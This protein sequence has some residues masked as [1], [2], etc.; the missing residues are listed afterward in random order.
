[1]RFLILFSFVLF[2]CVSCSKFAKVQK[3]SDYNLKL[4]AANEYYDKKNYRFAQQLYEELFPVLKGDPR[5]EDLYFRFAY[6]SYYQKDYLNAEN[7]FKSF[8]EVFPNSKKSEEME[9]MRAYCYYKQSPKIEL[10]QTNTTRAVG[11]MQTFINT[12]PGSEK[13][14]EAQQII[15]SG[16][17]KME[18]KELKSAELYY[19]IGQYKAAAIA[20]TSLINNYPDSDK[21]DMYKLNAIKSYYEYATLSVDTKKE[22]RFQ[23]VITECNDFIDRF[24]ESTLLKQ[25]QGY[26]NTS[27]NNIKALKNEQVKTAA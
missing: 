18:V 12:H 16:R 9:Y 3:S 22:E 25:V 27:Q 24:P 10:D 6:C 13:N 26:L 23:Q 5:F 20:F 19:S 7:L 14:K 21:S 17:Q 1:M 15:E 11:L 2:L 8:V 4:K